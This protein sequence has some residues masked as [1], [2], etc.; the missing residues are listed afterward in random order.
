MSKIKD[1]YE[2]TITKIIITV[3]LIILNIIMF[4]KEIKIY[5]II[6]NVISIIEILKELYEKKVVIK[7]KKISLEKIRIKKVDAIAGIAIIIALIIIIAEKIKLN[8]RNILMVI[9]VI[10]IYGLNRVFINKVFDKVFGTI[11]CNKY[12]KF[13]FTSIIIGIIVL[14]NKL[15]KK[16]SKPNENTKSIMFIIG[17]ITNGGAERACVNIAEELYKKYNVVIVTYDEEYE[18]YE[19]NYECKVP[20]ITIK[21]KKKKYT[22]LKRILK[23]MKLKKEKKIT[24]S[25]SFLTG[26]NFINV[27]SSVNDKTI[28][29]IRNYISDS[30][31]KQKIKM[32]E[33][34][35]SCKLANK[36]V[37]VSKAVENDQIKNLNIKKEKIETIYNFVDT[38][39]ILKSIENGKVE[40]QDEEIFD[41]SKIIISTGRLIEQKGQWNLIR[42]FKKVTQSRPDAKLIILGE[43]KLKNYLTKVIKELELN[44]NVYILGFK[45]NPYIYMAK[46]DIF[47]LTSFYE[48]MSNVILESMQCGLP[49]IA[50]DSNGG[51]REIL[52]NNTEIK[53]KVKD[54]KCEEYGILIPIGNKKLYIKEELTREEEIMADAILKL[55]NDEK[56]MNEYARKSKE[57]IKEF[58]KENIINKWE[59][60]LEIL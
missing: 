18:Q 16:V 44:Q 5:V 29:S 19:K 10:S 12:V 25:I 40:P 11:I 49:I 30:Q 22:M 17:K 57:R 52:C 60:L 6:L 24:H 15:L 39:K 35:I 4:Y 27:I 47:I 3:F 58:S 23:I 55:L 2:L 31:R 33:H 46:S 45:K 59:E 9:S 48:G 37:T 14:R 36:I 28:I 38:E 26:A 8:S 56:I 34:K 7:D 1:E 43:G 53:D 42:A 21:S 50:T 41:C 54:I 51:N 32:I 20:V 13:T